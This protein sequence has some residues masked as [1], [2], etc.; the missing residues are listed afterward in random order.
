VGRR[1]NGTTLWL[2]PSQLF[3]W[4]RLARQ[5]L[6]GA[7]EPVTFAQAVIACEP[8]AHGVPAPV[9]GPRRIEIVQATGIRVM[10]DQTVDADALARI[11]GAIE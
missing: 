11:I 1:G 2:R 7:D 8:P 4:R 10:V 9:V 6:L 5:G 3:A